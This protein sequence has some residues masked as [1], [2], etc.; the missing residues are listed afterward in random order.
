MP[1]PDP[2]LPPQIPAEPSTAVVGG[3]PWATPRLATRPTAASP[4]VTHTTGRDRLDRLLAHAKAASASLI[5]HTL[6]LVAFAVFVIRETSAPLPPLEL[7]FSTPGDDPG[8][9]QSD[10]VIEDTNDP[11]EEANDTPDPMEAE[12]EPTAPSETVADDTA[13]EA[14]PKPIDTEPA[15]VQVA[16]ADS[17]DLPQ[18]GAPAVEQLLAGRSP[19]R[20]AD[21]LGRHGGS[22]ETESAVERALE[23][24]VRQQRRDGSWSLRGPYRDGGR[25]ENELAAT[26]MAMLALQGAG[27]TTDEGPYRE[28]VAKAARR[29][30]AS[31]DEDGRFDFGHMLEQQSM[32]AQAQ[33]TI[34]VC[35][36]FAMTKDASLEVPARRSLSFAHRAQMP[37]GGWRYRLPTGH[38]D[39]VGDMSV[40]GWFMMALKSGEM[41]G[42][43]ADPAAVQGVSGFL[44]KVFVSKDQGF[45]YQIN[46]HNRGFKLRPA[47]TAEG[48]LCRQYLGT[49]RDAPELTSGVELLLANVDIDFGSSESPAWDKDIY[50]WYYI[51]QVCHHLGGSAWQ[52]WN[53]S[54]RTRVPSGQVL[55]GAEKGSW[56]PAYDQWGD[57]GGRLYTTCLCTCMLEVYYRHLP[58]YGEL[59]REP[60]APVTAAVPDANPPH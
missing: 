55:S 50:A 1:S 31:Q 38:P 45:G 51:T 43:A 34:A 58:L 53:A 16:A 20:R 7:A 13:S 46:G 24:I 33:A 11:A 14:P 3:L 6:I 59:P 21:L 41:A 52:R 2:S 10:V 57:V 44:D 39:E 9:S 40:T 22:A 18:T 17:Q 29:L 37:D 35:E 30:I 56:D 12:S 27:N 4:R 28:A 5:V 48:L 32:Y 19:A 8:G 60:A 23:W 54:L 15:D 49:P 25:V 47:L 26:A 42:I 36:L